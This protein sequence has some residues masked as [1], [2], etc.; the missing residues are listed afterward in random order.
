MVFLAFKPHPFILPGS[1]EAL[2]RQPRRHVV[3]REV[4]VQFAPRAR[5]GVQAKKGDEQKE[6]AA[7]YPDDDAMILACNHALWFTT[8]RSAIVRNLSI[9]GHSI[10]MRR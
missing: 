10:A 5:H 6:N 9:S 2:M 8:K 1:V 3:V 4:G 7:F